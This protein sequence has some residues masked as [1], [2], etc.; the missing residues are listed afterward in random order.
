MVY[1]VFD[2]DGTLGDFM[3]L[4]SIVT[5]LLNE[6][7]D[8]E[9][10]PLY[11]DFVR[12]MAIREKGSTPLGI[13]RPGIFEVLRRVAKMK[14]AGTVAGVIIYTNNGSIELANF[15]R[16]VIH[17]VLRYKLFDDVIHFYHYLRVLGPDGRASSQKTWFE[18]Y[19]LLTLSLVDAPRALQP[20][21]V[22]FI[23]D[24]DHVDLA[25]KLQKNYVRISEYKYVP[26]IGPIIEMLASTISENIRPGTNL[27][28]YTGFN[29]PL[30]GYIY[31]LKQAADPPT[32]VGAATTVSG[33]IAGMKVAA[34]R[35]SASMLKALNN[36]NVGGEA[37]ISLAASSPARAS[38]GRYSVA[39][40]S[41][42]TILRG[43]RRRPWRPTGS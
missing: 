14:K 38:V 25:A 13:F 20:S 7:G 32:A 28:P 31:S 18:L 30:E 33:I 6:K 40:P 8:Y 34:S 29:G 3:V 22:L 41:S 10:N 37:A 39:G 9:K 11:V 21:D 23:D 2:M 27:F 15:V 17:R 5:G 4:W 43:T 19:H 26:P 24:Q 35:G 12:K 42:A 1:V 16:D 36:V